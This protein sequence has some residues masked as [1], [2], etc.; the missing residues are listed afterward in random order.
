[1]FYRIEYF[2]LARKY[3]P[4]DL[5]IGSPDFLPPDFVL[6]AFKEAAGSTNNEIYQYTRGAVSTTQ[7]PLVFDKIKN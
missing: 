3:K 6:D 5:G 1:M 7:L 4:I 2:E